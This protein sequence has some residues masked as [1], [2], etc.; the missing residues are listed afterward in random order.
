MKYA[1]A[2]KYNMHEVH[3]YIWEDAVANESLGIKTESYIHLVNSLQKDNDDIRSTML[4]TIIRALMQNKKYKSEFGIFEV[5]HIVTGMQDNLAVEEKSLGMGWMFEKSSL[6]SKLIDVKETIQYI[7]EYILKLPLKIVVYKNKI[8]YL[9]PVNSYELICDGE[10]VG[11]IGVVHP[12]IQNKIDKD[13]YMIVSEIN[14]TKLN[15][16]DS[17]AYKVAQVSKYPVTTLDFNF[18]LSCDDVYGTI[19]NVA[20]TIETDLS[21]RSELVDIF[22]NKEANN[23]SYTIRYYVTSMEHTLSSA[24]IESFHKKVIETFE[25]KNIHLKAE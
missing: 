23:K 17:V 12:T 6:E 14:V 22:F 3:S 18:V 19:E 24:E 1:L 15:K 13:K 11:L 7:F 10:S 8:N 20:N 4:P 5:G 25:K 16:K 2:D 21:Y 9:A